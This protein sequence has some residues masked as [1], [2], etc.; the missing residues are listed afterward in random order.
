MN[1]IMFGT[2]EDERDA[3]RV[4]SEKIGVDVE[5]VTEILTMD[6]LDKVKGKDGILIQQTG[7]L[8]ERIYPALAEMGIKQLATRSAGYDMFDLTLA[9]ENG[10][11]ITNVPAYSPNAIAEFAVTASLNMIRHMDLIKKNVEN[12]N[13]SWNKAILSREVRSMKIGI[14]GTGR[15]GRITGELFAGFGAEILGFDLYPNDEARKFMRYTDTLEEL[16][17]EVDLISIHMPA[18]DDNFHLFNKELFA[19][20][21]EGSFLINTARGSIVKTDDLLEALESNKLAGA[22]LDTYEKEHS[23]VNKDLKGA[24]IDD[25]VFNALMAREDIFYTPHIAFYTET[26][27]E[28]LVEGSLDATREILTT[29]KS[30]F[31]VN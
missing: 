8:D 10:L 25:E 6:T 27:V 9:K 20:M 14:V 24:A 7:K 3:A 1:L 13:F 28:N 15:I 5:T 2:R 29:G 11:A 22:A 4:W 19:Q 21:K 12:H 23:F 30:T 18:T 17:R 26:A 16:V 31:E